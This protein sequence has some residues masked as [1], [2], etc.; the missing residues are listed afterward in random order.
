VTRITVFAKAPVAGRVKTRLIPALGAEGAAALAR[1][2]LEH[3]LAEALASGLQVEL[4]GDPDAEEWGDLLPDVPFVWQGEGCLGE[5]LARAAQRVVEAGEGVLLIGADCPALASGRLRAAA[6][7]LDSHDAVLHPAED[8]GYVLLGLR[9]FDRS[10][11]EGIAWST[12]EVAAQT[13][14]RIA[15]LGWRVHV[16]EALRDIDEPGDLAQFRHA[17]RVSASSPDAAGQPSSWTL[18]QV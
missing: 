12:A 5:R 15:A 2:M 13:L 11:F 9:R 14:E 3:T 10:M 8:G 4:C 1:E 17:E 7:A 16:G 18:K 6:E